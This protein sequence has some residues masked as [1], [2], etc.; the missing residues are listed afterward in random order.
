[1]YPEL[2]PLASAFCSGYA[3]RWD[4]YGHAV[5]ER[6]YAKGTPEDMEYMRGY[7][8]AVREQVGRP[9]IIKL[10]DLID[11]VQRELDRRKREYPVQKVDQDTY[12]RE[13]TR[14]ECLHAILVGMQR[15]E[16]MEIE[17]EEMEVS[18]D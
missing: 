11:A 6:P 4:G 10:P 15:P 2:D 7:R 14:F 5:F 17:I 18:F 9:Q 1:M 8:I 16:E 3:A 12:D 13:V